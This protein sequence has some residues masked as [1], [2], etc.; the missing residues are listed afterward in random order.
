VKTRS[1]KYEEGIQNVS[2]KAWRGD[3]IWESWA[4]IGTYGYV[5]GA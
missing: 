5:E 4:P 3:A 2:P 1:V